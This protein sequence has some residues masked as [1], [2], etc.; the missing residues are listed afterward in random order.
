MDPQL[1]DAAYVR[2]SAQA[3]GLELRP[4][5]VPGVVTYFRMICTLAAAVNDFPLDAETESA[6]V[7]TP[8]PPPTPE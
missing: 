8:C 6:A 3:A 7:F 5:H 1:I 2:Q 4:E